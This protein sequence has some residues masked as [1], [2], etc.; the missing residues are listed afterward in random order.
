MLFSEFQ[1]A[2]VLIRKRIIKQLFIILSAKRQIPVF[3]RH[4]IRLH[5]AIRQRNVASTDSQ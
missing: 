3:I 4:F 2:K 1:C 5:V